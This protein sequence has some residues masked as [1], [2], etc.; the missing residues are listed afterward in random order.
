[1][2][3]FIILSEFCLCDL[4]L[5][6]R[7]LNFIVLSCWGSLSFTV[8]L[9]FH[10]TSRLLNPFAFLSLSSILSSHPFILP[11]VVLPVLRG[12]SHLFT[13]LPPSFFHPITHSSVI[14]ADHP[15]LMRPFHPSLSSI[16]S[17]GCLCVLDCVPC[18]LLT[19]LVFFV[20][21]FFVFSALL[22]LFIPSYSLELLS[23]FSIHLSFQSRVSEACYL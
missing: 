2:H 19:V 21:L 4:H 1:V 13:A 14:I 9:P 20:F 22:Q 10:P 8:P 3:F 6:F 18:C 11:P 15:S 17:G 12:Y 23:S 16:F 5:S 7:S